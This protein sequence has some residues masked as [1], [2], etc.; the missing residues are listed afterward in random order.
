MY[1]A[2]IKNG[3]PSVEE[4]RRKLLQ[5]IEAARQRGY[6]VIKI[7]H[8]Y[9]SS[10]IGGNLKGAL[11]SSLR[12][13]KKARVISSFIAG[14]NWHV[15]GEDTQQLLQ[16]YPELKRDADLNEYNEGITVVVL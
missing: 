6:K 16:Q 11:R 3:M 10:G 15:C 14:E 7:V 1:V 13:R 5:H 2:N 4:G 9:G 8:G 12:R